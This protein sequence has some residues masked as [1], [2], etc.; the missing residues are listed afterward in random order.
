MKRTTHTSFDLSTPA[1]VSLCVLGLGLMATDGFTLAPAPV[2]ASA[3]VSAFA[4]DTSFSERKAPAPSL[5]EDTPRA[6]KSDV[7]QLRKANEG[8]R[9]ELAELYDENKALTD[10]NQQL[11]QDLKETKAL[12]EKTR[13][14]LTHS[15]KINVELLAEIDSMIGF[16]EEMIVKVTEIGQLETTL[17]VQRPANVSR[18]PSRGYNREAAN[19]INTLEDE[20]FSSVAQLNTR[21]QQILTQYTS[22]VHS[23]ILFSESAQPVE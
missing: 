20:I 22:Q 21:C 13:F 3:P 10:E 17:V 23:E 4:D 11:V 15:R 14:E 16:S 8:L 19:D 5:R 12:L 2:D 1:V 6:S 9:E 7:A 18:R